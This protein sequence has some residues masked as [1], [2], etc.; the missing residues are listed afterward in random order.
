M[1]EG[2]SHDN[3]FFGWQKMTRDSSKHSSLKAEMNGGLGV[4]IGIHILH[5]YHSLPP[6]FNFILYCDNKET[7]DRLQPEY[8]PMSKK[9]WLRKEFIYEQEIRETLS[10]LQCKIRWKWIEGHNN[11]GS[12]GD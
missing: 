3:S 6:D 8:K 2:D 5:L 11:D 12:K 9:E 7:V 1:I 10:K 4:I